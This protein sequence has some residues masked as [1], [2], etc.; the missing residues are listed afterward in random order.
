MNCVCLLFLLA[1][2]AFAQSKIAN[3]GFEQGDVGSVP[4]GWFVPPAVASAGFG[5]KSVDQNCHTGSRCAMLTGVAKPPANTFGN[6]MQN[7]PVANY[8][9]R[10]IRL[11]AAIRVEGP[12]THAQMWL[13]LDRADNSVAFLENMGTRPVTSAEWKTYDITTTVP[14]DVSR[15]ALGVMLIGPGNAWVDDVNLEILDEVHKDKTEPARPLTPQGLTNLTAFA[16]LYGYVR[17]FHPSDQAALTDWENFAIDGVRAVEDASSVSDLQTRLGKLFL[18][19]A[20]AVQIF[21]SAN[22]PE[23]AV[24]PKGAEIIRYRHNG[25]GLP[26]ATVSFNIYKSERVKSPAGGASLPEPF[27]AVLIPGLS[28]SV[29]LALYV[30]SEGTLPHAPKSGAPPLYERHTEDRATRLAGVIIAWN[31]FQHFYPY[32]DVA[33]TDWP[34]ELP[35]ALR[36]AATDTGPDDYQ[37]TLGRLVAALKDGHGRVAASPPKPVLVPPLTLD[38]IEDQFVVTRVQKGKSE[39]IMPGDRILKI[40]GKPIDQAVAE[41]RSVISAATE[42]WLRWRSASLLSTCNSSARMTLDI[43]PFLNPGAGKTVELACGPPKSKDM[44]TYTEPRPEKISE[45][46]PG[47]LYVDLDRVSDADWNEVV[48]RLEKAKGIIFDMRGYPSQPGT[49]ALT[50]LTDS[51]IRSAKWN[52]PQVSQ[53]DRIDFAFTESGWDL[54]PAKPYFAAP[55]V[56]LTDGRAISYAETVMGIVENYKLGTIVGGPTAGTNGNVN[57]FQLPGGFT[58]TWTGMKVLKHDGSQHHGIGIRPTV[59]VSRTRKG[60]AEGRDEILLRGLEVV[61]AH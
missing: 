12:G 2:A 54:Q 18:P 15:I 41:A 3:P 50:H 16:R 24:L 38:W 9:L 26:S 32:F 39:G 36:T 10:R 47:I 48:P 59:P 60:V 53:P 52:V 44:E 33:K 17:F 4:P 19:V 5:A 8:N 25:V 37:K 43:E 49:L 30:D 56:F 7:L 35:K 27:S 45:L 22:R 42:Q 28:A 61:K 6:L 13:R 11:A 14:E 29:P 31:V 57:P 23:P 34:A 58:L 46:E 55:K 40:D 51:A 20:P 1:A 21:P